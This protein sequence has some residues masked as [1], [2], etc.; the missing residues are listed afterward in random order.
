MY[1]PSFST[2]WSAMKD[3]CSAVTGFVG[4][5]FMVR[6]DGTTL[7]GI[8][9]WRRASVAGGHQKPAPVVR[10]M[11]PFLFFSSPAAPVKNCHSFYRRT[12]CVV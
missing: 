5:V 3:G 2:M 8:S 10:A 4:S 6:A 12:L 7:L 1:F 11:V 9:P